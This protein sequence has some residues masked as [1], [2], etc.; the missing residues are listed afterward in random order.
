MISL[1]HEEPLE[2]EFKK[3]VAAQK[4]WYGAIHVIV[5]DFLKKSPR[6]LQEMYDISVILVSERKMR[7]LYTAYKGVNR[8]TDVLSFFYDKAKEEKHSQGELFICLTQVL[9]QARRY[10][11]SPIQ[12]VARL[13]IHGFLHI[14]GYDHQKKHERVVMRSLERSLFRLCKKEHLI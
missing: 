9:R 1:I 12:E 4:K 3:T 2:K 7:E 8:V 14:Y 11:V 6:Q 10:R 13:A 5:T